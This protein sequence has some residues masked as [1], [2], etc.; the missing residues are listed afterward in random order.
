MSRISCNNIFIFVTISHVHDRQ[1]GGP[2][3]RED[4]CLGRQG[5]RL[6]GRVHGTSGLGLGAGG[7][8][9]LGSMRFGSV[10][11]SGL[12]STTQD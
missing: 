9:E 8:V 4:L 2:H 11:H 1:G 3:F 6:G 10:G 5:S 12:G 7:D